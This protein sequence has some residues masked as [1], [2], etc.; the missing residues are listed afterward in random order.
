[1]THLSHK[2]PGPMPYA[3][4]LTVREACQARGLSVYQV[5]MSGYA[6]GTVDPGTVYRLARGDTGRIDLETLATVAGIIHTLSGQ[7]VAVAELLA[8][9]ALDSDRGSNAQV[10][11][12]KSSHLSA[13]TNAQ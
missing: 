7:P 8:L 12:D 3:A 10:H 4:R 2:T 1:M 11:G 9:E 5:A 6:T 13:G